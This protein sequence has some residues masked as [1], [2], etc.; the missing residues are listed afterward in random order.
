MTKNATGGAPSYNIEFDSPGSPTLYSIDGRNLMATLAERITE[1]WK[2]AMRSGDTLR[3]D[4]VNILRAAIKNA[5]IGNRTSGVGTGAG[6]DDAGVQQVI[7][8]EAKKRRDAIEEYQKAN[9]PDRAAQE[10]A[11]LEILQEFLPAAMSDQELEAITRAAIEE[12]G[13]TAPADMGKVMKALL[14]RVAGRADGKRV[15]TV[16]RQLLA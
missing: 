12:T 15:N 9:R 1:E 4:T 13:A 10:Q 5:E 8:R 6:L 14:P 2:S 16:V 3:R 11:E 7:E